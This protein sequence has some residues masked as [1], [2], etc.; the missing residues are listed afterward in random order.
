MPRSS[1]NNTIIPLLK[2]LSDSLGT[3]QA[4]NELRWLVEHARTTIAESNKPHHDSPK[5]LARLWRNQ[6]A[7]SEEELELDRQRLTPVQWAWLRQAVHDRTKHHKP[8]QYIIGDQQ[9]GKTNVRVRPPVLIPRWETEEWMLRLAEMIKADR[10]LSILDACTGTG[11]LALG[12]ASE[13]PDGV[14]TIWNWRN[15]NL[16]FNEMLLSNSVEFQRLDLQAPNTAA[17][18]LGLKATWDYDHQQPAGSRSGCQGLGGQAIAGRGARS[19]G[20]AFIVNLAKVARQLGL[21]KYNPYVGKLPRLVVEIGGE[22]QVEPVRQAMH[23]QGLNSTEVW[24]DMAG[25]DRVVLGY[26]KP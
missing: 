26:V 14:A 3:S 4:K 16:A 21:D 9:F 12:L 25:T 20:I 1:A 11:C 5:L 22:H 18:L 7:P 19:V 24:K 6:P 15:E 2:K 23:D 13:L 10:P 8:L 17:K